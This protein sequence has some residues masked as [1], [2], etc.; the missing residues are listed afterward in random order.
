MAEVNHKGLAMVNR[1]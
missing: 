1:L